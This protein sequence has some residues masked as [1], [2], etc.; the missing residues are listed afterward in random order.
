MRF[1]PWTFRPTAR[2][3]SRHTTFTPFWWY[4]AI[5]AVDMQKMFKLIFPHIFIYGPPD[6]DSQQQQNPKFPSF[7]LKIRIGNLQQ[8]MMRL[9]HL[10]QLGGT[11]TSGS[12]CCS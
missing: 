2:R 12:G 6:A 3:S 5:V 7:R 11:L 1:E 10:G 9:I 8:G 4:I